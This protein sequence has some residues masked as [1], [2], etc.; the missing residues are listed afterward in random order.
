METRVARHKSRQPSQPGTI[1]VTLTLG[2]AVVARLDELAE[3]QRR[4]R[5]NAATL[6]LEQALDSQPA[7]KAS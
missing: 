1:Q 4:S 5:S 2:R 3:R 7:T 6:L